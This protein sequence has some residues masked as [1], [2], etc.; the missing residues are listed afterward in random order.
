M[1]SKLGDKGEELQ[2]LPLNIIIGQNASG[3]SNLID[4]IK[5]L[6]SLSQDSG[7]LSSKLIKSGCYGTFYKASARTK[8]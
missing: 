8:T 5:L 6:R 4:V 7:W 3:K 1:F 2:L